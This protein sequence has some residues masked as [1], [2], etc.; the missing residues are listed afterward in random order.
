MRL[1]VI[2]RYILR[3]I[4]LACAAVLAVLLLV[5]LTNSLIYMLGQVVDGRIAGDALLP[6]LLANVSQALVML[7]PPGLYLGVLLAFGRLYSDSEMSALRAG[8]FGPAR[9]YRPV[10]LAGVIVSVLAAFLSL[11]VA[12]WAERVDHDLR[13]QIAERSELVGLAAGQFTRASGGDIVLFAERRTDSGIL[14]EVFVEAEDGSG[15]PVIIRAREAVQRTDEETGWRYIE[16]RDG[17]RYRGAP[18]AADLAVVDFE[19]HGLRLPEQDVDPGRPDREARSLAELREAGGPKDLAEIQWRLSVPVAC[20]TLALAALPLARTTPRKGRYGR[21]A[22]GLLLY[23]FYANFMVIAREAVADGTVP[24][25][26]GMWWAHAVVLAGIA[27]LVL[28]Q[29][30]WRWSFEVMRHTLRKRRR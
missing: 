5:I 7:V 27:L 4:L 21:V 28:Q 8:G 22:L 10:S 3:E 6:L 11:Q 19:R 15:V 17:Q 9:L 12:P 14:E 18:G 13:V 20:M 26:I 1:T 24:G 23:M 30:G 25:V 2:D 29:N 16:F